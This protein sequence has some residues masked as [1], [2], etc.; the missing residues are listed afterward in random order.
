MN[1][2]AN[3]FRNFFFLAIIFLPSLTFA[4]GD[5]SDSLTLLSK[6]RA[7]KAALMSAV[8]PG[9]GQIYNKKYWKLP[10]LYG[11]SG[12]LIYFIKTNND[13]FNKFRQALIYRYDSD[14]LTSD[15]YPLYTDEDLTVRKNYYRRNRDLSYILAVVLYSLNIVDAYV[16]SQLMNF[17]VSDNLSLRSGGTL[18]YLQDG[19][20]VACLNF[21]LTFK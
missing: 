21:V 18:N 19:S 10:I 5:E 14:S 17:D 1:P 20:P 12:A 11:A 9:L 2:I 8:V 6:R 7:N 3:Q 15:I 16:D 13:E 4:G